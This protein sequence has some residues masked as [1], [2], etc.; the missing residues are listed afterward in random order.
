MPVA[1]GSG[2]V[3]VPFSV[4]ASEWE[5]Q[6]KGDWFDFIRIVHVGGSVSPVNT[7]M[8]IW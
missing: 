4:N 7:D 1:N 3:F 5:R 6:V 2:S 8:L